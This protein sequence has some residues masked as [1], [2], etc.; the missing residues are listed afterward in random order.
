M[1]MLAQESKNGAQRLLVRN[2]D[3]SLGGPEEFDIL[4]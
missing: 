4:S 2:D 1:M 3:G